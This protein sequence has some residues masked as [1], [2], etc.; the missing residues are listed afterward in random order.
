ME[1]HEIVA[2]YLSRSEQAII[3]TDSKYG[4]YLKS[5]AYHIL[6]SFEDSEE[7][8]QDTYLH[9]WNAIPPVIPKNLKGYVGRITHNLALNRYRNDHAKRRGELTAVL[10]ELQVADLHSVEES[11]EVKELAAKIS[12]FLR[13]QPEMKRQIFV[14]RYWYYESVAEIS[15][16]TGIK[17]ERISTELY[18]MRKKL[19]TYLNKEGFSL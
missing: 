9:A 16:E 7:C 11:A 2:L 15:R 6:S 1:D 17:P 4:W 19:L 18:R 10:D 14:L 5:I 12:D 3:E 8:V 13:A